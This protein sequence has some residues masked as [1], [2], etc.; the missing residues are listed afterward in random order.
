[1]YVQFILHKIIY[2]FYFNC[3]N[4]TYKNLRHVSVPL[5]ASVPRHASVPLHASVPRHVSVPLHASVPR[6]ASV[7]LHTL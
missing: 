6:H 5:H 7:P 3:S 2:K 4:I 1:M